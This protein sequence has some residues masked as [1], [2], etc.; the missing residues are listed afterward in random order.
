MVERHVTSLI[1]TKA[2]EMEDI[3]IY[4]ATKSYS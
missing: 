4:I 3:P 2:A 1:E